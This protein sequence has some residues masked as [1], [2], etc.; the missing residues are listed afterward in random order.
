[1]ALRRGSVI[2]LGVDVILGVVGVLGVCVRGVLGRRI[3]GGRSCTS[4]TAL[5]AGRRLRPGI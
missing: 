4:L 5:T 1:M 2:E 3:R